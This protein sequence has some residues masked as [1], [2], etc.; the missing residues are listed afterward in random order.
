MQEVLRPLKIY[1][2]FKGRIPPTLWSLLFSAS[3]CYPFS[4]YS[5]TQLLSFPLRREHSGYS[6]IST[7]QSRIA[8]PVGIW[9][10]SPRFPEKNP[11]FRPSRRRIRIWLRRFSRRRFRR[12]SYPSPTGRRPYRLCPCR[13]QL[14]LPLRKTR[15]HCRSCFLQKRKTLRRWGTWRL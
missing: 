8:L 2:I 10:F 4:S 5:F 12:C 14:K 3:V 15:R 13:L 11:R 7:M 1:S 9:A 6:E